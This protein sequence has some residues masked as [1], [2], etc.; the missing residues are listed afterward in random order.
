MTSAEIM[1]MARLLAHTNSTDFPDATL[2]TFLNVVKDDLFSY[3]ITWADEDWNWDI[4]TTTSVASQT[5]YVVPEAA[6]DTAGNLKISWVSVNY[7]GETFDDGSLKYIK[8]KLVTPGNLPENWNYYK[9]KQSVNA[10]I[11]YVADRS[12]FIAPAPST[13]EARAL[14]IELKGIKSIVDYDASTIES[15]IKVPLYLHEVLVQGLLP[16]IHRS[17]GR[18]DEA[19][20]EATAYKNARDLAVKKFT[21]RYKNA[22]YMSYPTEHFDKD[23]IVTLD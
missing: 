9:N 8:A 11:F 16:Y 5:E 2:L 6:S 18:K 4:W 14:W 20:F 17:E 21:D 22:Y 23:Y 12:V 13:T 1:S 15:D 7:D 10:P 3:L 19:Q